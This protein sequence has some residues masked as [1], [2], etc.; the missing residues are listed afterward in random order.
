MYAY[1]TTR[2]IPQDEYPRIP[3]TAVYLAFAKQ[4]CPPQK[5]NDKE[6]VYHYVALAIFAI[7]S[8]VLT[9]AIVL[10]ERQASLRG[11]KSM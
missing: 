4:F 1:S 7:F 5:K 8:V 6:T 10:E 9:W 2:Q 11:L 3:T